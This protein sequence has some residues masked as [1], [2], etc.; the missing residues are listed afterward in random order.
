[1][2]GVLEEIEQ[3]QADAAKL[4][5]APL[6]A[7]P[8]AELV[9]CL[10]TVHQL[11]QTMTALRAHV[12][13]Q[14]D[15]RGISTARGHRTT[16]GWLRDRL[17]LDGFAA[18]ELVAQAVALDQRPDVDHALGTG[19]IDGRHAAVI[20]DALDMLPLEAGAQVIRDAE[21][22]LLG[23]AG[24]FEPGKLRRLGARI[25]DH[26]APE[27][28]ER[29]EQ[30]RL[31]LAEQRARR[32]RGLT[33]GVPVE[34]SVRVSGFLTVED[35]AVVR[36]ALDPLCTPRSGDDRDP[37]QRRADA[38][39]DICQLALRTGSLPENG[40]EPAQLVVTVPFDQLSGQLG[41]GVL[42]TGERITPASVR[43]LACDAQILPSVLGG[44][45]QPLDVG[46]TRRLFAGPLRR[47]LVLRDQGCAFPECDRPAR[48][49]DAHHVVSW[50]DG[51]PTSLANGVLLCRRHHRLLHGGGWT[52]RMGADELP[53]FIPPPY[54]DPQRRPRRNRFHRRT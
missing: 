20:A 26:V 28:A 49:C 46:R 6:W 4:V 53:E 29:I 40:G 31:E 12:V 30:A 8:D 35:A 16:A 7:L 37:A 18:R 11:V 27:V 22:A 50:V 5:D 48:W 17:R 51:G 15:S 23:F 38:L 54:V 1:M 43:Q 41:R 47:A 32:R 21:A 25:L 33:L 39:V 52:V 24:E 10:D 14:I 19:V 2:G 13:R 9:D 42:D 45:G 36:A 3:L 34:G 44:A